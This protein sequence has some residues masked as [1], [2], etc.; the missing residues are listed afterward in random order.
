MKLKVG[1]VVEFKNYEDM[2]GDEIVSVPEGEFP[3]Y[4]KVEAVTVDNENVL[5]FS[6]EGS[7]YGFSERS[8]SRI[9]C[10]VDI[11][12]LNEGDEVLA[13][14]TVKKVFDGFIQINSSVGRTDVLKILKHEE[15][16]RFI[17][18]ENHYG[19]YIGFAREL[20][21]DKSK[22]KLHAS[23]DAANEAATDMQLDDWDVIPYDD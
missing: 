11:N 15:P 22:A 5:Y 2:F 12:N 19:M 1:D 3:K 8:V 4:G 10:D 7:Q 18:Q 21:S 6:I 17:V 20:V 16:E 13:K 23:L 9:I 14:V